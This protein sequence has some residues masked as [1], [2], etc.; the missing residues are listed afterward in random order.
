MRNKRAIPLYYC[1]PKVLAMK[2]TY[3]F[4]AVLSAVDAF[5]YQKVLRLIR[6]AGA[7]S[8]CL[9]AI[10]KCDPVQDRDELKVSYN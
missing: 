4:R 5:D 1:Q 6:E 3:N 7:T 8:R 2:P 10:T 9:G